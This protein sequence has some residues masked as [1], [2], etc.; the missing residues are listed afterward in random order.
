MLLH[1]VTRLFQRFLDPQADAHRNSLTGSSQQAPQ[2]DAQSLCI[3]VPKSGFDQRLGHAITAER[4]QAVS[5]L[6]WGRQVNPHHPWQERFFHQGQRP[7]DKLFA[8][9]RQLF[10]HAFSISL[11][12]FAMQNQ[13]RDGAVCL[14]TK[15]CLKRPQQL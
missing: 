14:H 8:E 11:Q 5:H 7:L 15:G 4:H 13:N 12:A 1:L 10:H 9:Q 2:W 3:Q 6:G